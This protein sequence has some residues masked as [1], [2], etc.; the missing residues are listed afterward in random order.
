MWRSHDD[1][2]LLKQHS[3]F[4][5][6]SIALIGLQAE[7]VVFRNVILKQFPRD[8]DS[9]VCEIYKFLLENYSSVAP[10][11]IILYKVAITWGYA[12][13]RVEC[14][15]SSLTFVDS[16]GRSSSTPYRKCSLSHL[17]LEKRVVQKISF[18]SEWCKKHQI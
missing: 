17:F 8:S 15:F 12:S 6:I 10:I 2:M 18:V 4:L 7:C 11:I 14:L 16:S 5:F 13:A 1:H 3:S 9:D